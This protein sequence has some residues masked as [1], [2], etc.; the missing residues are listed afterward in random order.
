M[1]SNLFGAYRKR[2][3]YISF[4]SAVCA[5]AHTSMQ[6]GPVARVAA[7]P[8]C[9][10]HA[11]AHVVCLPSRPAGPAHPPAAIVAAAVRRP[12]AAAASAPPPACA[13]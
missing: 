5:A 1:S 2:S 12:A 6:R 11:G 10:A 8:R 4:R 13:A 7:L 9:Q 3:K